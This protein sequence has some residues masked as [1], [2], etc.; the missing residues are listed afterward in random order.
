[1]ICCYLRLSLMSGYAI[2]I[3]TFITLG[4]GYLLTL[5][6]LPKMLNVTCGICIWNFSDRLKDPAEPGP[7][8]PC[9]P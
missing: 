5:K 8:K 2:L 7:A 6:S 4:L 3:T 1:M 9:P